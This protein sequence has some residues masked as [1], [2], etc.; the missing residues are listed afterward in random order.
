MQDDQEHRQESGGSDGL[1]RR[2]SITRGLEG[3][4]E[5]KV[6]MRAK[7]RGGGKMKAENW[8]NYIGC[9]EKLRYANF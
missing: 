9:S 5:P 1:W 6:S 8:K 4:V 7:K 3:V 2:S